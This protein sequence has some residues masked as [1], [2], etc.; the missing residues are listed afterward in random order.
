MPRVDLTET[1]M[2]DWR[3]A[4]VFGTGPLGAY[5]PDPDGPFG[6]LQAS[7][8]VI[9]ELADPRAASAVI[10]LARMGRGDAPPPA[11]PPSAPAPHIAWGAQRKGPVLQAVRLTAVAAAIILG[12]CQ[13]GAWLA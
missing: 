9:D 1:D 6:G 3:D 8:M 7:G 11:I 10:R 12:V 2:D 5:A 4:V 13:I